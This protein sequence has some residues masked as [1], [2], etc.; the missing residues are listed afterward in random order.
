MEI[1]VLRCFLAVAREQSI[2]AAARVLHLSQPALSRQ[3][4]ELEEELGVTL[5]IRGNRKTT[6]T[7]EGA[8]LRKRAEQIVALVKKTGEEIG[9][10]AG[11]IGGTI[12][13]GAAETHA[14]RLLAHAM[15]ALVASHP[16][17]RLDLYSGNAEDV[18]ERLDKGLVDFGLLIEPENISEYDYIR[19]P[20]MVSWGLLILKDSPL[21]VLEAIR[22]AD[23]EGLPLIC[24]SR[25]INGGQFAS[26]LNISPE[27]LNLRCTY[28]LIFNAALLVEAGLGYCLSL[29]ELV[30]TGTGTGLCFRPLVPPLKSNVYLVWKKHQLFSR[31]STLFL[32]TV[33][34][35][36]A[37]MSNGE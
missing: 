12:Y 14:F 15:K 24:S 20:D 22:P 7:A 31:A 5:F 19:L 16:D 8:L 28:N 18:A 9:A 33:R 32:D 35:E 30:D 2:S 3:M 21:A 4:M 11:P 25:A 34:K 13:I 1:R 10:D 29:E 17:I 6:L 37:G 23:L 36:A 26:W 27:E